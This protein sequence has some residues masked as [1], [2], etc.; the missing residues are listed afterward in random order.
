MLIVLP[1]PSGLT[2]SAEP[3]VP[4]DNTVPPC[5]TVSVLL[6][7]KSIVLPPVPYVPPVLTAAF[8]TTAPACTV[9]VALSDN[10]IALLSPRLICAF[11]PT[12][13]VDPDAVVDPVPIIVVHGDGA[14]LSQ[15]VAVP[16]VLQFAWA[17]AGT[18]AM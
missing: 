5:S 13:T 8:F 11:V 10:A 7:R 3:W 17:R 9:M 2:A 15:V 12:V 1:V 6:L 4:P 18:S 14:V 16:T